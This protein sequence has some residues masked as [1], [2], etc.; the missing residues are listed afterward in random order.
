MAQ[1]AF[2]FESL[3]YAVHACDHSG[4]NIN[5]MEGVRRVAAAL[6]SKVEIA[7]IDVDA[8]RVPDR[9]YGLA[10]SRGTLYHL[11]NL[12]AVLE[13][14]SHARPVLLP[15]YAGSRLESRPDRGAR[16]RAGRVFARARTSEP[17]TQPTIGYSRLPVWCAW[18][19]AADG[20]CEHP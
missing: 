15:Q 6:T 18:P 12:F 8:G 5:R 20:A 4:T 2:F 14:L 17:E 13:R 3:G 9:E 10:V 11:N 7:D 19:N 1:L 16:P